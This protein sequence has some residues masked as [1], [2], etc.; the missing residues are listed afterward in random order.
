MEIEVYSVAEI[1]FNDQQYFEKLFEMSGGYVL[2]F[3][4]S[5]FQRFV[6]DVLSID[7]YKNYNGLSK[8]NISQVNYKRI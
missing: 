2:N 4:N 1:S 6:Y 8:A 3:S 5:S 7:I